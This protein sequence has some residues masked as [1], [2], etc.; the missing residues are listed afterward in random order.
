M[1][2]KKTFILETFGTKSSF[3]DLGRLLSKD[4]LKN[5]GKMLSKKELG[6]NSPKS[7]PSK[8]F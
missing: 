3:N 5:E 2:S 8:I 4:D 7:P 6:F 1:K